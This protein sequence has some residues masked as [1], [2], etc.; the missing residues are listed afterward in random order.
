[1]E[2]LCYYPFSSLTI[3]AFGKVRLCTSAKGFLVDLKN[4]KESFANV[5]RSDAYE[6]IR[7]EFLSGKW[8]SSCMGCKNLEAKGLDSKRNKYNNSRTRI[9]GDNYEKE[10]IERPR[11]AH[12]SIAF[13]NHCNLRCAMC[14][15]S[16]SSRWRR[17]AD[18]PFDGHNPE[19]D[20]DFELD[21]KQFEEI[22]EIACQ[23]ESIILKGGEPLLSKRLESFLLVLDEKNPNVMISI[24]TNGTF[25]PEKIFKKIKNLKI[26]FSFSLESVFD[27]YEWIREYPFEKFEKNIILFDQLHCS[28][29][30]YFEYTATWYGLLNFQDF[31]SWVSKMKFTLRR[32]VQVALVSIAQQPW[33]TPLNLGEQDIQSILKI[34]Y[35]L[36]N[37]SIFRYV[38]TLYSYLEYGI[39][40]GGMSHEAKS[41]YSYLETQRGPYLKARSLCV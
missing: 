9:Y 30:I 22:L 20:I 36:K 38:N 6:G 2:N 11:I 8:P 28:A 3:E 21:D 24:Q 39:S 31:I 13:S 25:F 35:S 26:E 37:D 18:T 12:L 5:W 23:S 40:N 17:D 7:K 4:G 19:G 15:G 29:G 33:N 16:F 34:L 41:Y 27:G 14:N 1:M 10:I 32:L